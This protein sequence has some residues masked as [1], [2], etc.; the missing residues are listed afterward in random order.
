MHTMRYFCGVDIGASAAKLVLVDENRRTVG[1]A[2][3][4]SGVDYAEAAARYSLQWKHRVEAA[5]DT[6]Q[7][8]QVGAVEHAPQR[9]R[10]LRKT[11]LL[12]EPSGRAFEERK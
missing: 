2:I 9:V 10:L 5:P 3:R 11:H 7:T 4:N 6:H 1:K 12:G 8:Q